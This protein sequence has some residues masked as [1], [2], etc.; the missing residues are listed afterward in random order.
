[1]L[2]LRLRQ[3][4]SQEF[5]QIMF[6]PVFLADYRSHRVRKEQSSRSVLTAG[7]RTWKYL[8][9]AQGLVAGPR[10][11]SRTVW[12]QGQ[13]QDT[14]CV[15]SESRHLGHTW[16]TPH[17]NLVERIPVR[18]DNLVAVLRPR[19]IANLTARVNFVETGPRQG[20]PETNAAVRCAATTCQE[21]VLVGRPGNGLDG[22][23]VFGKAM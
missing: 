23:R 8:P 18:A 10:D 12:T 6:L 20:V 13:V 14:I 22:G 5:R 7:S 2:C 3:V 9:K 19:Q 17:H 16:I 1:M 15:A 4:A 11:H 21:T